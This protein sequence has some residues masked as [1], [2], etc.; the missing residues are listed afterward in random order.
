MTTSK[1]KPVCW[2]LGLDAWFEKSR[3]L[4]AV[5]LKCMADTNDSFDAIAVEEKLER[6]YFNTPLSPPQARNQNLRVNKLQRGLVSTPLATG[7]SPVGR[8]E[9][10][11]AVTQ[12]KGGDVSGCFGGGNMHK[13]L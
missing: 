11:K 7:G 3:H 10:A 12:G 13:L 6:P 9:G 1:K 2:R 8:E 5:R 4:A